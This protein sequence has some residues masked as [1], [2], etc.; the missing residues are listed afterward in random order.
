MEKLPAL[1]A[2]MPIDQELYI[3]FLDLAV[4]LEVVAEDE[5]VRI[6]LKR[7]ST[8]PNWIAKV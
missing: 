4:E 3:K 5:A 6:Y 2:G 7:H 8:S 1:R